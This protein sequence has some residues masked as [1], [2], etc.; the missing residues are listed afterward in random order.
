MKD[1]LQQDWFVTWKHN[2]KERDQIRGAYVE[3]QTNAMSDYEN[4][5]AFILTI[6]WPLFRKNIHFREV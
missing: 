1:V 2:A 5:E 3:K 6:E 4:V